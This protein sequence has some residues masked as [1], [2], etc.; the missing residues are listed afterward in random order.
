MET[1]G[2]I[3][4]LKDRF[5]GQMFD[6]EH[7]G[8]PLLWTGKTVQNCSSSL[9]N[10]IM[11]GEKAATP[12]IQK[13][14]C[15]SLEKLSGSAEIGCLQAVVRTLNYPWTHP[16]G[17]CPSVTAVI[18]STSQNSC[19]WGRI[20][21]TAPGYYGSYWRLHSSFPNIK[22][23]TRR[24]EALHGLSRTGSAENQSLLWQKIL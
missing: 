18:C 19:A 7:S 1:E 12:S 10:E 2:G 23:T 17:V 13:W 4:F 24:L 6:I 11:S 20:K 21:W 9:I 14:P 15:S 5:A 3:P 8:F 22:G 16:R